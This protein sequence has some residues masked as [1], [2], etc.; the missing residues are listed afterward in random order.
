MKKFFTKV[1]VALCLFGGSFS[2]SSCDSD[3]IGEIIGTLLPELI[4]NIWGG[5]GETNNYVGDFSEQLLKADGSSFIAATEA[6]S[7]SGTTIAASVNKQNQISITIPGH[8]NSTKTFTITDI[9]LGNLEIAEGGALSV[10]DN[11]TI[12]GSI[13]VGG[14]SIEA[15]NCYIKS[16]VTS[17]NLSISE[18]SIYFG[19]DVYA[20]NVKF[21]GK[22][23][24]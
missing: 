24:Q 2:F 11:S 19:D 9:V 7:Y 23:A 3:V 16:T 14:K 17:G 12:S 10:G 22:I 1:M 15:T 18:M 20:L 4:G 13:T 5:S 6:E 21:E 8:T